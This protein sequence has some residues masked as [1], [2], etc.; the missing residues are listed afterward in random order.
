[1]F[2][3]LQKKFRGAMC[4][5]YENMVQN[6]YNR[7]RSVA[8]ETRYMGFNRRGRPLRG[9]ATPHNPKCLNFIKLDQKFDIGSHNKKMAAAAVY[10]ES[11][12]LAGRRARVPERRTTTP[13]IRHKN[14]HRK[15]P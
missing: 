13:R 2:C 15:Y 14:H 1:M 11:T 5:F 3:L 7:F 12:D 4:Q 9:T 10:N 8:D 6:G